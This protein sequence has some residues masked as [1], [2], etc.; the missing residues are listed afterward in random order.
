MDVG[1]VKNM[2]KK[3][4][5]QTK[6]IKQNPKQTKQNRQ[7]QMKQKKEKISA[8]VVWARQL[9]GQDSCQAVVRLSAWLALPPKR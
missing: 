7:K 1:E 5:N 2:K 8:S 3:T 9:Q 4:T 6:P